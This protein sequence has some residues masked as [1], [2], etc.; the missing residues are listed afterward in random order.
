MDG[1]TDNYNFVHMIES[2]IM[3]LTHHNWLAVSE[4]GKLVLPLGEDSPGIESS[5]DKMSATKAK[6][7]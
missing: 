1:W 7:F 6:L 4:I 3:L 5:S 2:T